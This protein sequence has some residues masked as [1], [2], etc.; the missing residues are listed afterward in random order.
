MG[1][2][3]PFTCFKN[4]LSDCVD[5]QSVKQVRTVQGSVQLYL[6]AG[7]TSFSDNFRSLGSECQLRVC[8]F[9]YFFGHFS[10]ICTTFFVTM[11][12]KKIKV[13]PDD[14]ENPK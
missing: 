11:C 1:E 10:G 6:H 8:T 14:T 2:L 3:Y 13:V 7:P 4:Y 12:S 9:H 5:K